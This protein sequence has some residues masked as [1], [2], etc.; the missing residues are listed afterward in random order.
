MENDDGKYLVNTEQQSD[1]GVPVRDWQWVESGDRND[2]NTLTVTGKNKLIDFLLSI[3]FTSYFF[4]S[5]GAPDKLGK[6]ILSSGNGPSREQC[7]DCLGEYHQL[8]ED[9]NGKPAFR[10]LPRDGRNVRYVIY[11]GNNIIYNCHNIVLIFHTRIR[12]VHH[13]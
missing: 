8:P 4:I 12:L 9:Y 10:S 3:Y 7:P 5:Q 11:I 2:D 13:T 6:M 1:S